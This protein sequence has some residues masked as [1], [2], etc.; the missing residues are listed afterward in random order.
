MKREE[1]KELFPDATDEQIDGI[2]NKFGEELNPVKKQLKD[3]ESERDEAQSALAASQTD[4]AGYKSQLDEANAKLEESMTAEE[5]I[6]ARE[7]AAEEREREFN[8]KSNGLDAKEIFVQAGCFEEEE[9]AELVEQVT[10]EDAEQT[11]ARAQRIVDTVAKQREAV[12]KETRAA[13]LKDNPK[14]GD[15]GDGDGAG[16]PKTMKEYLELPYKEQ[17]ALKEAN[18]DILSQLK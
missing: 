1:V 8:L 11:K 2:L 13:L 15:G 16:I 6:A 5:R 10:G 18:P 14:L 4:A 17:I 7:Q 12:A 3:A 9:I